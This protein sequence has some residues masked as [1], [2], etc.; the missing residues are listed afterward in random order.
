MHHFSPVAHVE[1]LPVVHWLAAEHADT[2]SIVKFLAPNEHPH[3]VNAE[4]LRVGG[5][6]GGGMQFE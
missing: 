3:M 1:R 6:E 5:G 4:L 2:H